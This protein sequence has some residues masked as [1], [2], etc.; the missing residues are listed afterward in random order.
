MKTPSRKHKTTID[1]NDNI[2]RWRNTDVSADDI[3]FQLYLRGI[4]LEKKQEDEMD[5]LKTKG[6]GKTLTR[7]DYLLNFVES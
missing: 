1:Y 5:R 7:K 3:M 2:K 4:S 6:K